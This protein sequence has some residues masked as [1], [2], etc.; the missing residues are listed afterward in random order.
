MIEITEA[1]SNLKV[2]PNC[3]SQLNIIVLKGKEYYRCPDGDYIYPVKMHNIKS[4][5]IKNENHS[6]T[7][8]D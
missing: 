8:P 1:L 2:C 4:T 6:Y 7:N 3:G 5:E